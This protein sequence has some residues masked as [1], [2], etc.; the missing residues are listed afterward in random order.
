MYVLLLRSIASAELAALLGMGGKEFL[1]FFLAVDAAEE[2]LQL[3]LA[4]QLHQAVEEGLRSRRTSGDIDVDRKNLVD[5]RH[6]AIAIFERSAGNGATAAGYHIFRLCKLL[7]KTAHGGGHAMHNRTLHH[8]IVCLTGRVAGHLKSETGHIVAGGTK[9]HEF[10]STA[11]RAE[12]KRP[13]RVGD[14]PVDEFVEITYHNVGPAGIQFLYKLV[15]IFIVLEVLML[16]RLDIHC[17]LNTPFF[18]A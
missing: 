1:A 5:S 15:D 14:T 13:Q 16:H 17:H 12:A 9:T 4:L 8:D 18:Q 10:N 3:N 2:F 11:A 7:V 6:H